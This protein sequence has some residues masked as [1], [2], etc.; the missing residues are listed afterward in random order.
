MEM[1]I[2]RER[3]VELYRTL[4]RTGPLLLGICGACSVRVVALGAEDVNLENL[5]PNG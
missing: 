1:P 3:R 2:R 4:L 5:M